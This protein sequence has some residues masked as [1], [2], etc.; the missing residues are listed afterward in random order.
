MHLIILYFFLKIYGDEKVFIFKEAEKYLEKYN[1]N[2]KTQDKDF[3]NVLK[4]SKEYVDISLIEFKNKIKILLLKQNDFI[5]FIPELTWQNS[6]TDS[7]NFSI[8]WNI[9]NILELTILKKIQKSNEY[10]ELMWNMDININENILKFHKLLINIIEL[11]SNIRNNYKFLDF[12]LKELIKKQK[13]FKILLEEEDLENIEEIYLL[14]EYIINAIDNILNT[15]EKIALI[16]IDSNGVINENTIDKLHNFC[17]YLEK[18]EDA[19]IA[20]KES[21]PVIH[22]KTPKNF[23]YNYITNNVP[24]NIRS[25]VDLSNSMINFS[26]NFDLG[27]IFRTIYNFKQKKIIHKFEKQKMYKNLK[28]FFEEHKI[29]ENFSEKRLKQIEKEISLLKQIINN[30]YKSKET[31]INKTYIKR[32]EEYCRLS[33]KHSEEIIKLKLKK[34]IFFY[35]KK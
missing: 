22:I 7:Y 1:K 17:N 25:G 16:I 21:I 4:L 9:S 24:L 14:Y 2:F 5:N 34:H 26:V 13:N 8:N 28:I 30:Y 19:L 32:H 11:V 18:Q 31:L 6:L 15:E 29:S 23:K 20:L 33:S 10:K 12:L 27:E 35:N 3:I